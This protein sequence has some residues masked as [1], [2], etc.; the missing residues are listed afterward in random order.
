MP[1]DV[2][3]I[4]L[5]SGTS[6]DGIDACLAQFDSN[7]QPRVVATKSQPWPSDI[8]KRLTAL[9]LQ[10]NNAIDELLELDHLCAH[11]FAAAANAVLSEASMQ[12][13]E[14]TAIGSHGQTVRHVPNQQPA[15]SLQIGNPNRIAELTGITTVADFRNRDIA[16]GGQGA[17][18]APVFHQ[19]VFADANEKRVVLNL[20]GIANITILDGDK[21]SGFDTGPANRLMDDWYQR[22]FHKSYDEDGRLAQSGQVN[23][24]LLNAL[25]GNDYFRLPA[26]KSTGSDYFNLA[27]LDRYLQQWLDETAEN[28]QATLSML[29]AQSIS[30]AIN[31]AASDCQ[32][33]LV[34]GGGVHNKHLMHNLAKLNPHIPVQS[35][36]NFGVAPDWVEAIAFAWLARQT[37]LGRAGN[38][39]AVTGA[40]GFR[41]LGGIYPA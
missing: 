33:I 10:E 27:W 24:P 25:L 41:I 5:M 20:G 31:Q 3:Y 19:A 15:Y 35:S 7:G 12:S 22:H 6:L 34:C 32:R 28:V 30:D 16:A 2:Y 36:E 11:Q 38:N 9:I 23:Q 21:V 18:L 14:I 8:R 1:T 4:G 26:P 40:Q 17:P 13:G 29:T 37:L 39:P